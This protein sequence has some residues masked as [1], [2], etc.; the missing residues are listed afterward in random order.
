MVT[1]YGMAC[2]NEL[3]WKK[4]SFSRVQEKK[5]F[6]LSRIF[7]IFLFKILELRIFGITIIACPTMGRFGYFIVE[8]LTKN[9]TFLF[10]NE[11]IFRCK[12]EYF[13]YASINSLSLGSPFWYDF[14]I[15]VTLSLS[16]L[17]Y[18]NTCAT[19]PQDE[20]MRGRSERTAY[21]YMKLTICY[22]IILSSPVK[23]HYIYTVCPICFE[24]VPQK[25]RLMAQ[26]F[27]NFVKLLLKPFSTYIPSLKW[28]RPYATV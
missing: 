13:Y 1:N 23:L 16:S 11:E 25:L 7:N 28:I 6:Q 5:K 15:S 12:S 22:N 8:I 3:G 4:D 17:W 2:K 26:L 21:L 20:V 19:L 18:Y 14:S 27:K 9:E 24:I 10:G